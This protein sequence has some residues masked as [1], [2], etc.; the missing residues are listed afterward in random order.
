MSTEPEVTLRTARSGPNTQNKH[1]NPN[2]NK[3]TKPKLKFLVVFPLLSWSGMSVFTYVE[4]Y[5]L[6]FEPYPAVLSGPFLALGMEIAPR[7][8][9]W[10]TMWCQGSSPGLL[11]SNDSAHIIVSPVQLS[12]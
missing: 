4:I 3:Q 1:T 10:G 9:F 8:C 5:L 6:V 11:H 7:N 2:K 12:C